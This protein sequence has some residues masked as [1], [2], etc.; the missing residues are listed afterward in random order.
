MTNTVISYPIPPYQ[1]VPITPQYYQPSRFVISGI[2]L[3][4]T[5]LVTTSVNHN[6]VIGQLCRLIIPPSFG[7]RQLNEQQGYVVSIPNP[8]QVVLNINSIGM[9]AYIASNA[10]TVAQILAIGDVNYGFISNTG[11]VISNQLIPGSFEN[12]SPA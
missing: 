9:D 3:G 8:N 5:T 2:T 12:I 4:M 7:T 11:N 6:Y 1:N 10:T